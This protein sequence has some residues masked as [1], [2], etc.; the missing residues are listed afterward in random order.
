MAITAECPE[1]AVSVSVQQYATMVMA[2]ARYVLL[3][4][5]NISEFAGVHSL[6][7]PGLSQL[8]GVDFRLQRFKEARYHTGV[9]LREV[10]RDSEIEADSRGSSIP[11]HR[12]LHG[13]QDSLKILLNV[14]RVLG[15]QRKI[16]REESVAPGAVR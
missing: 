1:I 5:P 7:L 16:C 14:G 4:R 8:V 15:Q 10:D 12:L 6:S 2:M 11:V 13:F 3:S 9:W